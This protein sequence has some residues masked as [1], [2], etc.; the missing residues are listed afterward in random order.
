MSVEDDMREYL[1]TRER[2]GDGELVRE[3]T[4]VISASGREW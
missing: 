3:N 2:I 4:M 1:A